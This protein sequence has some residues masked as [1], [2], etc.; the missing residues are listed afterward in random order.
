MI[1]LM[2][3][4]GEWIISEIEE[5]PDAQFGDPD[6]VLKYPYQIEG[7]CLGTWPV[8]TEEREIIVRS[9][10]VT[11][12][13]EPKKFHLAQYAALVHDERGELEDEIQLIEE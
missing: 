5:I 7:N 10:D 6:C 3:F 11:V 13:S 2:K 8:Y 12:I 9:S 4:D 1:K